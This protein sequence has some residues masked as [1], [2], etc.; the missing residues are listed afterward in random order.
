MKRREEIESDADR[1][2]AIMRMRSAKRKRMEDRAGGGRWER[3]EG[4]DFSSVTD[5]FH[6]TASV[7]PC[8]HKKRY[9]LEY[10]GLYAT[11]NARVCA[12]YVSTCFRLNICN[13][14]DSNCECGWTSVTGTHSS[15]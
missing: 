5:S 2:A 13:T 15:H 4:G 7:P 3:K 12:F 1:A 8:L 10:L 14:C 6:L 9:R 11:V